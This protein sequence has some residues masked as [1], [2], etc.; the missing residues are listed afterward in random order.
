MKYR[1]WLL[2]A[3]LIT[4]MY[5]AEKQLVSTKISVYLVR[6]IAQDQHPTMR[7][8]YPII[9]KEN[10]SREAFKIKIK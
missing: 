2:A 3:S 6:V 5:C 8:V 4:T 10:S 7:A 1:A 9:V